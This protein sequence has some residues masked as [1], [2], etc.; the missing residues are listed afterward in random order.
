MIWS[1]HFLSE[2][3]Y[4]NIIMGRKEIIKSLCTDFYPYICKKILNLLINPTH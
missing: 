2:N 1:S 4:K 3:F